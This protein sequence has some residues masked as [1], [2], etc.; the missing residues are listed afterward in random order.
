M[1]KPSVCLMLAAAAMRKTAGPLTEGIGQGLREWWGGTAGREEKAA[2]ISAGITPAVRGTD[3]YRGWLDEYM[4]QAWARQA[5][6]QMADTSAPIRNF[7]DDEVQGHIRDFENRPDLR[8][9]VGGD[10]GRMAAAEKEALPPVAHKAVTAADYATGFAPAQALVQKATGSETLGMFGGMAGYSGMSHLADKAGR[11]LAAAGG[12]WGLI[13]RIAPMW[14]SLFPAAVTAEYLGRLK[15]RIGPEEDRAN[16][17]RAMEERYGADP[18][19]R[20]RTRTADNVRAVMGGLE[21]APIGYTA[22]DAAR[23]VAQL[24]RGGAG[25]AKLSRLARMGV[26]PMVASWIPTDAPA[27]IINSLRTLVGGAGAGPASTLGMWAK[28]SGTDQWG[29]RKYEQAS[30]QPVPASF[31]AAWAAA[32]TKAVQELGHEPSSPDERRRVVQMAARDVRN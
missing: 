32:R 30:A 4:R 23:P 26:A 14:G 6:E 16:T 8:R 31:K 18:A 27:N 28:S 1:N 24:L 12:P 5:Q 15:A 22:A 3:A 9:L 17:D 21:I 19:V 7:T 13:G 2:G 29:A 20:A 10:Y 11:A 25:A